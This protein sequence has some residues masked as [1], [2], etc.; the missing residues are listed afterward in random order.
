MIFHY[1]REHIESEDWIFNSGIQN[2]YN[3][4]V[5]S[6]M[7]PILSSAAYDYIVKLNVF[8]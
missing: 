6:R 5:Y 2:F 8:L 4:D 7:S 3:I 1:K